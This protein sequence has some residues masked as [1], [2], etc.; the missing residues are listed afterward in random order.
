[1][2]DL[3]KIKAWVATYPG[4]DILSEFQVDYVDHALPGNAGIL[5]SGL[6][7]V[8]RQSDIV[9]HVSAINQYNF[10]I[11][12]VFAKAPG[13]G[14][15]A[16]INADWV[17]DFQTWVQAQSVQ[18]LAPVFGDVPRAERITAQNGVLYETDEGAGTYMV[19]LSVLFTKKFEVKNKWLT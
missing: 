5:P 1:M 4:F 6:V 17:M 12:C 9:G 2:K 8:E 15:G 16:A 18:G 14:A 10:G 3:E 19:Q 7:E 13:D 11:Y